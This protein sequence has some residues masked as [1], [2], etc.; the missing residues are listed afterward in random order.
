[1]SARKGSTIQS[2]IDS[3]DTL[4][5]YCHKPLCCHNQTL[6]LIKL[7]DKFGPDYGCMH[8]DIVP[9]LRCS[10]CGGKKVGIIRHPNYERMDAERREREAKEAQERMSRYAKG[11]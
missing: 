2:L 6:D 7:R 4:T 1:M 8:D 11:G 10:K 5:A 9:K 3:G